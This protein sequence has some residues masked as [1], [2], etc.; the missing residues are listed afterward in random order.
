MIMSPV[1]KSCEFFEQ[2]VTYMQAN[3]FTWC[4]SKKTQRVPMLVEKLTNMISSWSL[5]KDF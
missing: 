2:K 5:T 4:S 1:F 3:Y